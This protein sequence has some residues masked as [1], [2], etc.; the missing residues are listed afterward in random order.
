MQL[1]YTKN[2]HRD[3]FRLIETGLFFLLK[4]DAIFF[5]FFLTVYT[6]QGPLFD[7]SQ[8]AAGKKLQSSC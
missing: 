8:Y 4:Q 5:F 6:K 1:L 3:D 2:R 7:T